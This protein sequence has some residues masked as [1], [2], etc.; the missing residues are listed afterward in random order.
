MK[1][2]VPLPTTVVITPFAFTRRMQLLPVSAMKTLPAPSTATPCGFHNAALVAGPPSPLKPR[3]LLPA[4]VVM[5]PVTASTRRM[6][7][8]VAM[9]RLPPPSTATPNG[10]IKAALVPGPPSPLKPR[11]PF[12]ATIAMSPVEAFSSH[13]RWSSVAA[14]N[15]LPR[16]S[17]A[18]PLGAF[19]LVA[20]GESDPVR[21]PAMVVM[22]HSPAA[23]GSCAA[24]PQLRSCV[25]STSMSAAASARAVKAASRMV[26]GFF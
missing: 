4:N 22:A 8:P 17:T 1:P 3:V 26:G 2:L 15:M 18:T 7:F 23:T 10:K 21:P 12:P 19:R 11:T 14:I 25:E 20:V 9:N 16:L 5:I 13:T 6:R 24:T